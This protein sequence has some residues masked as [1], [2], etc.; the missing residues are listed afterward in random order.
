MDKH[1][2]SESTKVSPVA[3]LIGSST[4]F[5]NFCYSKIYNTDNHAY[6]KCLGYRNRHFCYAHTSDP[7]RDFNP[8]IL[9]KSF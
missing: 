9:P 3:P 6:L 5:G 7:P 2:E 8:F 1:T 4:C